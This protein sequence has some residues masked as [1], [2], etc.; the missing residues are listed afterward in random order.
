[1]C[2]LVLLLGVPQVVNLSCIL[3]RPYQNAKLTC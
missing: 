1:M 2:N 3:N